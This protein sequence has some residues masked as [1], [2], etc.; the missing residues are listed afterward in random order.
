MGERADRCRWQGEGDERVAAVTEVNRAT[1]R[2]GRCGHR[3]RASKRKAFVRK[4]RRSW[5]SA[6]K[7]TR[8]VVFSGRVTKTRSAARRACYAADARLCF[9]KGNEKSHPRNHVMHPIWMPTPKNPDA[10]RHLGFFIPFFRVKIK[11]CKCH[12]SPCEQELNLKTIILGADFHK[13]REESAPFL[14]PVK[15]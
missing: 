8:C 14:P 2:A 9:R 6:E 15:C 10:T 1:P 4:K 5:V 12:F 7:R 11:R 3:N 13:F